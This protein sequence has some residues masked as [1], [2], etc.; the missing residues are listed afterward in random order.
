VRRTAATVNGRHYPTTL[1]MNL[2][3]DH[4]WMRAD[5]P[6]ELECLFCGLVRPEGVD[7][8]L[9]GTVCPARSAG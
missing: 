9:H 8:E 3:R 5:E 2:A 6:D 7:D 4:Y 1:W